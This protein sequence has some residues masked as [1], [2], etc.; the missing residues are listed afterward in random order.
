AGVSYR[1]QVGGYN[2]AGGNAILNVT[3]A[4]QDPD[5]RQEGAVQVTGNL[6]IGG[7]ATFSVAVKNYGSVATPAIHPY[8]DGTNTVG[9]A[10]R[11]DGSA[12]G[13]AVIQPGQTVTFTLQQSLASAGTWTAQSLTLWNNETGSIWKG[14]PAN[15]QNQQFNFQVAMTCAPRPK[16]NVTTNAAGD[17]RLTVTLAAA[18]P[19]LGNRITTL[20]FG[21]DPR[22][23]T[24]N[25]YIDL[26]GIGSNRTSPTT[27]SLPS[28]ATSYTFYVR[29]QSA[30]TPVT[31]PVTVTDLC[32]GWQT[33][34]GGGVGAGF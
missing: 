33:V 9:Q 22:T 3:S 6:T 1:V 7:T 4:G 30:G 8:L 16:V 26:P 2:S 19:E 31:L 10:W 23:P 11:A 20:Q 18:F 14:L 17:G 27:V 28:P 24:P 25:A 12:P 15:G 34:V 29:R 21:P 5:P 32:G 13:S